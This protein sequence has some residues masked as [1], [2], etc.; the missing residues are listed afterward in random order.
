MKKIEILKS[1]RLVYEPLGLSHLSDKYVNW[2]NDKDVNI[3][4][5]SGGDYTLEKLKSFL[6]DQE[7]KEIFFWA[8]IKTDNQKHI[9]NIK[10]D[11]ISK[12]TKSGEYGIM[13]GDKSE[14]GKGYANEASTTIIN[15]CFNILGLNKINLGVKKS[16]TNAI[17]LYEKLGFVRY[18]RKKFPENYKNVKE[19]V[20]RMSK[21]KYIDKIILGTAQFGMDYGIN[22]S[23][24]KITNEEIYKIL[25]YSYDN[26]IRQLDTAEVYGNSIDLIGEFHNQYPEKKFKVFS[27]AIYS[28]DQVD[29]LYNIESNLKKLSIESYEGYMIHNYQSFTENQ[30]LINVMVDAK[31]SGL[32]KQNGISLYLNQEVNHLLNEDLLDFIQLPFNLLDN[33]S[34][35]ESTFKSAKSSNL[36]IHVRSIFLQGLFFKSQSLTPKK[37]KPLRKYI[38][39]LIEICKDF[40]IDLDE[41]AIKY[42]LNKDYINKIIFGIDN[43]DQLKRNIF[44]IENGIKIPTL[45]IDNINVLENNLLNPTNW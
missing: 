14:W 40:N 11:P 24:G 32:I 8:I 31:R 41:L 37:I 22:N 6:L 10:I 26:G 23:N 2:M 17:K 33:S 18:D 35:R 19:D 12:N 30:K 16:N 20:I 5:D 38:D 9:G 36:D 44:I 3:Y 21:N 27:K 39:Q 45:K 1:K 43:L 4:M 34:K 28:K 25:E 29:Y 42:T 13:I 15:Y 7:K